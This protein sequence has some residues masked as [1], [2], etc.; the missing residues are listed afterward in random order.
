MT[1]E[2]V[3]DMQKICK[4]TVLGA[5][6]A[7]IVINAVYMSGGEGIIRSNSGLA[8]GAVEGEKVSE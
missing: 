8:G 6:G 4:K 7:N 3:R 2:A 1:Y 5:V